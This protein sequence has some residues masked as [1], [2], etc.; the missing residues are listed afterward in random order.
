MSEQAKRQ[1]RHDESMLVPL[2]LLMTVVTGTVDAVSILRLG[3]VF[4]ANMTG[5]VVFLGFGFA[6]ASG[7]SI[8]ASLVA[9]VAFLVGAAAWGRIPTAGRRRAL[10]RTAAFQ[11]VL[12]AA[13]TAVGAATHGSGERYVLTILL[14]VAMGAQNVTVR[15]LAVAD[16]TTTVLTLTLTGLAADRPDLGKSNSHT[17]RRLA[18][19]ASMLAGAVAGAIVVLH[20]S[21][22]AWA[23]GAATVLLAAVA[24]VARFG[25]DEGR[26]T[27]NLNAGD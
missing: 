25:V 4:V 13:A 10:A 19:V 5:N 8:S 22:P 24:V 7:F 17:I 26:P 14:A 23:L 15:R 1:E 6:G 12:V 11:A 9:L 27:E 21:T 20:T 3:H 16:M 18:A 2:L